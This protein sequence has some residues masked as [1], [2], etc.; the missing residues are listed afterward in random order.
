LFFGY[1][2]AEN[3]FED[4]AHLN[5]YKLKKADY[6][7]KSINAAKALLYC[8]KDSFNRFKDSFDTLLLFNIYLM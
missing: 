5:Y 2:F 6:R 3:V 1:L 4:I 8:F 7:A